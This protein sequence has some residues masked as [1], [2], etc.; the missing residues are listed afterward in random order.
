MLLPC[1]YIIKYTIVEIKCIVWKELAFGS[2]AMPFSKQNGN[3]KVNQYAKFFV[4]WNFQHHQKFHKQNVNSLWQDFFFFSS[5]TLYEFWLAQLFLSISS[6]PASF[7]SNY[8][9]SSSSSHSS[10]HPPILL[11]A[12]P[13]V[14]LHT[15][16]LPGLNICKQEYL[17]WTLKK[18]IMFSSYWWIFECC[19]I[20][21][22]SFS[23]QNRL[24]QC[25]IWSFYNID[26]ED[27][28]I[29]HPYAK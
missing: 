6:S 8:S 20:R 13:S 10:R 4:T 28:G 15:V 24:S 14:L 21:S 12:F 27:S 16:S 29:L 1:D 11:L 26:V 23:F 25:E 9:L 19:C 18:K 3:L 2:I 17:S 5:T 22:F 7:V